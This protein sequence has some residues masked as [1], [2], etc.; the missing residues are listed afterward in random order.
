MLTNSS[1]ITSIVLLLMLGFGNL[2]QLLR[3]IM[4]INIEK[5]MGKYLFILN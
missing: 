4:D 3:N 5:N 2:A 1:L